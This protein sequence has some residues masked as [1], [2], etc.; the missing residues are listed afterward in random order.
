MS[1]IAMHIMHCSVLDDA[2]SHCNIHNDICKFH[3]LTLAFWPGTVGATAL[4][5]GLLPAAIVDSTD[6]STFAIDRVNMCVEDMLR[7]MKCRNIH[8]L[9][10]MCATLMYVR[11][12]VFTHFRSQLPQGRRECGSHFKK[13]L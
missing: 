1:P 8:N 13:N 4:R 12:Y 7:E 10:S 2:L 6:D 11:V 5:L 9:I 3:E